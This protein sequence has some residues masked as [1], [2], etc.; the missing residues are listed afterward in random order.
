MDNLG[1]AV[2]WTGTPT[3]TFQ[4][5][6]SNDGAFFFPLTFS[7][8]LTQPADS[9]GGYGINLNQFPWK[10]LLLE[11]TN[12]SGSGLITTTLQVKDLN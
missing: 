4:V 8:A 9:S 5:M 11:Y 10:Y 1:L 6:G 12:S 7:P 2:S 3:G